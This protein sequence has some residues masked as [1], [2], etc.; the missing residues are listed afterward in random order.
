MKGGGR[1]NLLNVGTRRISVFCQVYLYNREPKNHCKIRGLKM[2]RIRNKI[3][4]TVA[5][6]VFCVFTLFSISEVQG[7]EPIKIGV[8]GPFTGPFATEGVQMKNGGLL[9]IEEINNSG[10][11]LGRPLE[12]I[13][14]DTG[15]QEQEK[16]MAVGQM[17]MSKGIDAAIT[18]WAP[19][20]A[21]VR[22]FGQHEIIYLHADTS[23]MATKPVREGLPE[24]MWS[25]FQYD[26]NAE[27]HYG[28]DAVRYFI[29]KTPEK[30]GWTPPNKKVA[31][32]AV[33]Y[34]YNLDCSEQFKREL[35]KDYEVIVNEITPFGVI[36][37]GAVLAKIRG[38]RPAFITFWN[39]SPSDTARFI[40]QFVEDPT[41]SIFYA[42]YAPMMPEFK[43]IAKE[44]A[45]GVI[46]ASTL[47]GVGPRHEAFIEKYKAKYGA[48]PHAAGQIYDGINIWAAAVRRVGSVTARREIARYILEYPYDGNCGHYV[49]NPYDQS[50]LQGEGLLPD[51][52]FQIQ[53]GTTY[54]IFPEIYATGKLQVPSWIRK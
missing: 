16:M 28:I 24:K 27:E 23:F 6:T 21:D 5:A 26:A 42:Q 44:A 36:D 39:L 7:A 54:T 45:D 25:V 18:G 31:V 52:F 22:F 41:N 30:M 29:E 32:I 40:T 51:V 49:F 53:K 8:P 19:P 15:A 12:L 9:A 50:V 20:P 46:F 33:D 48:V 2:K 34:P 43:N 37:W 47:A 11:V 3:F 14:G 10:G 17:L 35:P 4:A 13:F 1:T 38:T